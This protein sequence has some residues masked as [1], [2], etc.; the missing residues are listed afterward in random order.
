MANIHWKYVKPLINKAAVEDFE[1][2][3]NVSFPSD[4]KQGIKVN[5]GGRPDKSTFDTN[6]TTERVFKTLLSFNE[7]D[8]ETI[9][10]YFPIIHREIT[11]LLPF[12]SD[13]GGNF[14]CLKDGKVVLYLHEIGDIESVAISFTELMDKLYE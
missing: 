3:Y 11:S 14:L 10:K 4:L 8:V 13:P 1:K 7:E 6:K 9:Y 2:K 5:N 12:A